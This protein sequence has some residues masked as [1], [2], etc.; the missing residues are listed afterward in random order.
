MQRFPPPETDQRW[1]VSRYK[2]NKQ[3]AFT[4]CHYQGF[5][6]TCTW[7]MSFGK[8]VTTR[9]H[10]LVFS[11]ISW[12]QFSAASMDILHFTEVEGLMIRTFNFL[13]GEKTWRSHFLGTCEMGW[14]WEW[15]TV[16]GPYDV[17]QEKTDLKVFIVVIPK[18]GWACVAASIL[19]L[20]WHRF[21][22]NIIYDVSRVKLWKVGVIPKEGWAPILLW[23]W[24]Q[25]P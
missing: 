11:V 1:P 4:H 3:E 21:F 25:R 17:R 9:P 10:V 24:R 7:V 16:D 18:E 8:P 6:G 15:R 20:V 2:I 23:V 5:V 22:E 13:A 14:G 12:R 19:L